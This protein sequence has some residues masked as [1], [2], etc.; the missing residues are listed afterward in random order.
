MASN[1]TFVCVPCRYARK[2]SPVCERCGGT[3]I[4]RARWSAPSKNNDRAWKRIERG[5]WL[6]SRRRV[7]RVKRWRYFADPAEWSDLGHKPGQNKKYRAMVP[8]G[9]GAKVDLGD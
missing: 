6:W 4:A 5:E 8:S 2:G 9:S 7:R 1:I 3:M